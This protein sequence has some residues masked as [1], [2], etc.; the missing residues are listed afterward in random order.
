M[1]GTP[2]LTVEVPVMLTAE[3]A[4]EYLNVK[5]DTLAKW[6]QLG[7]G[8]QYVKVNQN[9]I[10]YPAEAILEWFRENMIRGG[11]RQKGRR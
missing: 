9:Y 8:P 6:R 10:R 3:E 2:N 5:K 1:S 11:Q 4:A 7:V